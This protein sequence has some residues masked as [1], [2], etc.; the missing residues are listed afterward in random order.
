MEHKLVATLWKSVMHPSSRQM[1]E[2]VA[3]SSKTME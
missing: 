1:N 3:H 2:K